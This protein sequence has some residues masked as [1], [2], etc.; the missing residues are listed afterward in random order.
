MMLAGDVGVRGFQH[1]SRAVSGHA[2]PAL[3]N[4]ISDVATALR[5]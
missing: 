3:S 1:C 5:E 2:L 4:P